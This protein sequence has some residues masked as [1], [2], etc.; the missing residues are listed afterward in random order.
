MKTL[1]SIRLI[2]EVVDKNVMVLVYFGSKNC[3]VCVDLRPKVLDLLEKY[4]EIKSIYVDVEKWHKVGVAYDFFTIPGILLF[5]QGKESIRRA[6]HISIDELEE[7]IER[8]YQ[9]LFR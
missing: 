5:I 9:M 1:D 6:R 4:P 7:K 3:G 8:Y 2:E